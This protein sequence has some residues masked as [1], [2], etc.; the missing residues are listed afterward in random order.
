MC[1]ITFFHL[2]ILSY[3]TYGFS[4]LFI[5]NHFSISSYSDK[6]IKYLEKLVLR[7]VEDISPESSIL[8]FTFIWSNPILTSTSLAITELEKLFCKQI[9]SGLNG[10]FIN[11]S[12]HLKSLH[13]HTVR[14]A[15]LWLKY[16]KCN[17]LPSGIV[18]E[19]ITHNEILK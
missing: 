17:L 3:W 14:P 18:L 10:G 11:I 2:K 1:D 9:F 8:F 16:K 4:E 5:N 7:N 12:Q 6:T 15:Y 13:Q 19:L